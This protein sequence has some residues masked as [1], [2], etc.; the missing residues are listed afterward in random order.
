MTPEVWNELA[1]TQGFRDEREMFETL[2]RD[3]SMEALADLIGVAESTIH[4]RL[5]R[6]GIKS[7]TH[8]EL[9]AL[10][11]FQ[12]KRGAPISAVKIEMLKRQYRL[13]NEKNWAELGRRI[14]V[15]EVTAKK[16]VMRDGV[17]D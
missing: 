12:G 13:M 1:R 6:L 9:I 10:H 11:N 5:K 14:G 8:R 3:W 17:C 7:R 16:Y 4:Y 15:S 2:Y